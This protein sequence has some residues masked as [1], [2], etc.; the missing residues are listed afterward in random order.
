M[1]SFSF[2]WHSLCVAGPVSFSLGQSTANPYPDSRCQPRA[3]CTRPRVIFLLLIHFGLW[4]FLQPRSPGFLPTFPAHSS[5]RV[6]F[7]LIKWVYVLIGVWLFRQRVVTVL[8]LP[9]CFCSSHFPAGKFLP[10]VNESYPCFK[11]NFRSNSCTNA[12]SETP[13]GWTTSLSFCN[14]SSFPFLISKYLWAKCDDHP[15]SHLLGLCHTPLCLLSVGF[16]L[17]L[18]VQF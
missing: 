15:D 11:G 9:H 12:Y 14:I 7:I 4:A 17:F 5:P 10:L 1:A 16:M 13:A 18:L 2:L 6:S 8:C 3:R